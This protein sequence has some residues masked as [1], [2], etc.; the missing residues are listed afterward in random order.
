VY[1]LPVN[2][3]RT[4]NAYGTRRT[5]GEYGGTVGVFLKQKLAGKPFTVVGD[6]TQTRDF[7]FVS[8]VA[9]AFLLAAETGIIG[10]TW[11]L[12]AGNPQSINRLA[13]LLGGPGLAV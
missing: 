8:D 10:Q 2:S 11:N 4:F 3:M 13:E 12:G 9:A 5:S 7:I 1:R 6:G